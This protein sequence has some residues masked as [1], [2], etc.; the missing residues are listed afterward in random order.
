MADYNVVVQ[1]SAERELA[2]VPKADLRRIKIKLLA[3]AENPT[4]PGC[5][6]LKG[7]KLFRIRQG[8]WRIVYEVD[9]TS[10]TV[11]IVKVGHRREVY[12]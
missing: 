5:T 11:T 6:R 4:P 9:H 3:L 10:K 7:D 8:K 12:R 1:R 2:G